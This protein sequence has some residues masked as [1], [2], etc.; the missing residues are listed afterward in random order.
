MDF[1]TLTVPAGWNTPDGTAI[2]KPHSGPPNG[3]YVNTWRNLSWVYNDPCHWKTTTV[4]VRTV[5][6][7]V[8][9]FVAGKHGAPVTPVD[10]TISGFHGKQV[11]LM[12]PLDVDMS[13]CDDG[14]Y[15]M[16]T[17]SDGAERYNQGPGQHDILDI[18]DVNGEILVIKL[19]YWRANTPAD[20]A[21]LRAIGD[22]IKITP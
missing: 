12:V 15:R 3:M 14:I 17:L 2:G 7:A 13:K 10:I 20:L 1:I 5:D 19:S 22:S 9:A 4:G 6:A 21:E 18:L 11:D 8:A 16:F